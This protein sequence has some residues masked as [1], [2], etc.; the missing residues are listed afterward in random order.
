MRL[1]KFITILLGSMLCLGACDVTDTVPEDSI[2]DLNFWKKTD[3]LKLYANNF[4]TSL[5]S[6]GAGLDN[7]SDNSVTNSP[8]NRL[9]NNI[10]VPSTGG[11]WARGDWTKIRNANY[12]LTHYQTVEGDEQEIAHYVGEIRFFRAY[13]YF[14][15]VKTFGDVPWLDKDLTTTDDELLFGTR[16]PRKFVV[17]KIIEDLEFA[18]QNLKLP[19]G[20]EKGRL[21]KFAALQL[22]ARVCLYEGTWMKYRNISGWE[23]YLDKAVNASKQI[24]DDGS[25]AIVKGNAPSMFENYPLFYRQQFIEEDLVGNQECVLPRIYVKDKLMHGLS[26]ESNEA[27]WGISKDFIESFVCI[28]GLPIALSPLYRGDDSLQ[29]EMT[30]RDPRLRNMVDNKNLPYLLN[31]SYLISNKLTPVAVDKCPTGYM[32]SKFRNPEPLQNEAKKT[33]YDW[34][35]FRYA[36]VLLIYAEA[37]A[38]LGI[39]SQA[40]IDLSINKLRARLDEEGVFEMGRLSISP[41]KDPLAIVGGKPRYGYDI[42]PLLYEIRRERRIELAFEGFRWDDICRWNAGVLIENPKTMLGLVVNDDVIERYKSLFG[43]TDQFSN[44]SFY[45]FTD[46]DGRDKK[47]LK[48]YNNSSRV[49]DDKLYLSPLPTDQLSLNPGLLPQ[50]TGWN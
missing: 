1:Y 33:S 27:G 45:E 4:Y 3:D 40:D 28:D 12:F 25:Y 20:V 8:N 23:S 10:S 38:E 2:T 26:R 19:Q 31:G 29:L 37:K 34:Y 39:I 21:H 44:R 41:V 47:L 36:E 32:A 49:W 24:M 42:S 15:K 11:G 13:E 30:N 43:G 14:N 50:N 35:V 7:T 6:P 18:T 16:N 22:L 46:W 17:D 48:V 9:F 5:S